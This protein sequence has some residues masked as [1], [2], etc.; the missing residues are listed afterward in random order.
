MINPIW[1]GVGNINNKT[2]K[3]FQYW[4]LIENVGKIFR[5]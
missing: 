5:M 1:L 3:T 2:I 4:G